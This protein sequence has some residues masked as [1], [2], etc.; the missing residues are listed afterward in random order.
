M[1]TLYRHIKIRS[2][3]GFTLIETLVAITILLVVIIGPMTIA[4]RGMQTAF[5]A[6]DQTTAIYLAQEAIEYIQMLRDNSALTNYQDYVGDGSDGDG[7]TWSW[8][9][10]LNSNCKD[11]DGCDINFSGASVSYRDCTTSTNCRLN[12]Y[13]GSS[14]SGRVYAYTTGADWTPSIFTRRV[15]VGNSSGGGVP[16]TVTVTW[17]STLFGSART[18]TL[19]TYLYDMYRRF[20]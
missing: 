5:F 17:N 6:G 2:A 19:Q 4:N 18:I 10:A 16:V 7:N 8:Y 15:R 14:V 1:N 11:S 12:K 9:Q 3:R 13:T 20:E